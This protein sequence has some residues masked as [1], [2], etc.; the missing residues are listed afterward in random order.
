MEGVRRQV[1][2]VIFATNGASG[3]EGVR[4]EVIARCQCGGGTCVACVVVAAVVAVA[5]AVAVRAAGAAGCVAL[6]CFTSSCC[7][8]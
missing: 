6:L 8:Y 3:G 7:S 1:L 5:L 2:F 4:G